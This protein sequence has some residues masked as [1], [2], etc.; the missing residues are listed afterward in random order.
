MVLWSYDERRISS[1]FHSALRVFKLGEEPQSFS[2]SASTS[3]YKSFEEGFFT[4]DKQ[5]R[6]EVNPIH[7]PAISSSSYSSSHTETFSSYISQNKCH[8]VRESSQ[9]TKPCLNILEGTLPYFSCIH[10]SSSKATFIL[11]IR[12]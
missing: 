5:H 3:R 6:L 9:E 8:I 11:T 4:T 2:I 10:V 12:N 1:K 7:L